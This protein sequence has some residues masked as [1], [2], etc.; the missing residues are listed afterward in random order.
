MIVQI[1]RIILVSQLES[2]PARP[3]TFFPNPA[4]LAGRRSIHSFANL[5]V[6]P[7][8]QGCNVFFCRAAAGQHQQQHLPRRDIPSR[9]PPPPTLSS[10]LSECSSVV[11]RSLHYYLGLR[12]SY[13]AVSLVG[14]F[15]TS[16]Q[17]CAPRMHATSIV[18]LEF[19]GE[20]Q[21]IIHATTCTSTSPI[22]FQHHNLSTSQ[23]C[24]NH[25]SV[26]R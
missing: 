4:E 1:C 8:F 11:S 3:S 22:L 7:G 6:V 23:L 19:T 14:C 15:Y 12:W 21:A 26:R 24:A 13:S 5:K 10:L 20:K 9:R 2:L 18:W 16:A 17:S 25:E